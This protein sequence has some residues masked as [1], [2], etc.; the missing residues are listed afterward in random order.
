MQPFRR[1]LWSSKR[2]WIKKMLII[3][4]RVNNEPKNQHSIVGCVVLA[5]HVLEIRAS[6][7]RHLILPCRPEVITLWSKCGPQ[8]RV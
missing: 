2:K 4:F 8:A 7:S 1:M 3:A 6:F 5:A